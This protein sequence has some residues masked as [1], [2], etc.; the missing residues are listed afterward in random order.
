MGAVHMRIFYLASLLTLQFLVYGCIKSGEPDGVF[1][2]NKI[3]VAS[4]TSNGLVLGK[5][6]EINRLIVFLDPQCSCC[7]ILYDQIKLLGTMPKSPQIVLK[8]VSLYS[9]KT[10]SDYM[11]AR[12]I[13]CS[14]STDLLEKAFSDNNSVFFKNSTKCDEACSDSTDQSE[15]YFLGNNRSSSIDDV[16]CDDIE[17]NNN[18]AKKLHIEST[19]TMIFKDG[20]VYEGVMPADQIYR[21]IS[22]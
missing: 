3:S 10:S 19:P 12:A 17:L 22:E 7:A 4:I 9:E 21:I 2:K 8:I 1:L 20:A 15:K 14:G 11:L 16:K 5:K 18:L 6:S 13:A